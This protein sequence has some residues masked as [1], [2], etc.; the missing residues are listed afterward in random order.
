[1][2]ILFTGET[3]HLLLFLLALRA[4]S[5]VNTGAAVGDLLPAAAASEAC[6]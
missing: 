2:Y 3:D 1:M 4:L 5:I 6:S